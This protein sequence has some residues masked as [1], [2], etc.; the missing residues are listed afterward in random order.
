M[1][2]NRLEA[3]ENDASR[4]IPINKNILEIRQRSLAWPRTNK[5]W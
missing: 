4:S 2:V 5:F 3:A 1:E